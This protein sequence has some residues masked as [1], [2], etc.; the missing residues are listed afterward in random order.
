MNTDF[1]IFL[2]QTYKSHSKYILRIESN[3]INS[4]IRNRL[5]LQFIHFRKVL[6]EAEAFHSLTRLPE[7]SFYM[8]KTKSSS[9]DTTYRGQRD[10]HSRKEIL[11]SEGKE[12]F[13]YFQSSYS[14][15]PCMLQDLPKAFQTFLTFRLSRTFRTFQGSTPLH[16]SSARMHIL[17]INWF[18]Q[19]TS[20]STS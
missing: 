1:Q 7:T 8:Q 6:L 4:T 13:E 16:H 10:L 11:H 19:K 3:S 20:S 5:L 14:T 17:H 18:P 2:L 12:I 15:H 9:I